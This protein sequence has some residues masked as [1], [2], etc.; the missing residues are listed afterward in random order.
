MFA[1]DAHVPGCVQDLSEEDALEFAVGA[2][3]GVEAFKELI[4]FFDFGGVDG[5]LR[6]VDAVFAGVEEEER[7]NVRHGA[8][9]IGAAGEGDAVFGR[10]GSG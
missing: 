4:E 9:R 5:E 1:G 10:G 8:F 2:Q 3:V 6:G 7:V